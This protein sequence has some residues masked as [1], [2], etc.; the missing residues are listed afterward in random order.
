MVLTISPLFSLLAYIIHVLT[1]DE[2]NNSFIIFAS[3]YIE[4]QQLFYYN[5]A[6]YPSPLYKN[7]KICI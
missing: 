6:C 2:V 1:F 3:T 4:T 7:T 5:D